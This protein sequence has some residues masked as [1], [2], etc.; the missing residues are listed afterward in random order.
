[1]KIYQYKMNVISNELKV[2]LT[3]EHEVFRL[4]TVNY[5]N[6]LYFDPY[7]VTNR[8]Y[9]IMPMRLCG[10]CNDCFYSFYKLSKEEILK[11][12]KNIFFLRYRH[13]YGLK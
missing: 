12:E 11:W 2:D 1:M 3:T 5:D 7:F 9:R 10:M 13:G 4:T 6:T 8:D